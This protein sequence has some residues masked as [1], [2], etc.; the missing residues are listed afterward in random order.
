M[1]PVRRR[2]PAAVTCMRRTIRQEAARVNS[3]KANFIPAG[4]VATILVPMM[5]TRVALTCFLV[6]TGLGSAG[7]GVRAAPVRVRQ[8]VWLVP[9]SFVTRVV[10]KL[11]GAPGATATAAPRVTLVAAVA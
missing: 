9:P 4:H 5:R 2:R 3:L 7:P 11:A 6:L 8:G 1:A 10:P